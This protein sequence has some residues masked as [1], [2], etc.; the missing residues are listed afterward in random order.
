MKKETN[1]SET[2]ERKESSQKKKKEK[3]CTEIT[4]SAVGLWHLPVH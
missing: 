3:H 4:E 2:S 1:K